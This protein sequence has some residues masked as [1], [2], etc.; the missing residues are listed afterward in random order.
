[1]SRVVGIAG[2]RD[3]CNGVCVGGGYNCVRV[4]DRCRDRMLTRWGRVGSLGECVGGIGANGGVML[5]RG[6]VVMALV[7]VVAWA[8][9]MSFWL[10][11]LMGLMG[12]RGL[13][14]WAADGGLFVVVWARTV[15]SECI[16]G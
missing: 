10:V 6:G 3:G 4:V 9:V 11:R 1:M 13:M 12:K 5:G 16:D 14:L 7:T 15:L 2:W 8:V